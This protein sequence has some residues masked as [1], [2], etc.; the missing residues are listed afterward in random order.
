MIDDDDGELKPDPRLNFDDFTGAPRLGAGGRMSTRANNE[1]RIELFNDPAEA[2]QTALK[3]FYALMLPTLVDIY[4]ASVGVS[5]RS[6]SMLGMTK[7]VFL[8]P[9]EYLT[10]ILNV[11]LRFQPECIH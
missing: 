9:K 10:Q 2:R 8:C 4:S 5:V 6:K 3:R 1:H 11:R 7:V